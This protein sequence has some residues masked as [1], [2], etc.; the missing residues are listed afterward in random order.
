MKRRNCLAAATMV[1]LLAACGSAGSSPATG[2]S[3]V[4]AATTVGDAGGAYT[5]P[6]PPEGL[7][8]PTRR[9]LRSIRSGAP[10]KSSNKRCIPKQNGG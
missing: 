2:P 8:G 1:L 9:P 6:T 3:T 4:Q 10:Q 7:P 5:G